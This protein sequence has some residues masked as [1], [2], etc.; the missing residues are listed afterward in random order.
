MYLFTLMDLVCVFGLVCLKVLCWCWCLRLFVGFVCWFGC[1]LLFLGCLIS[2]ELALYGVCGF[3]GDLWFY[4]FIFLG[5]GYDVGCFG[6]LRECC[7]LLVL[8]SLVRFWGWVSLLSLLFLFNFGFWICGVWLW[9][10]VLLRWCTCCFR[11][12]LACFL[13]LDVYYLEFAVDLIV[14]LRFVYLY[15]ADGC[16]NCGWLFFVCVCCLIGKC[17][18]CVTWTDLGCLIVLV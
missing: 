16:C 18:L 6:G 10:F 13:W 17:C 2:C 14:W 5:F 11:A 9:W 8:A 4:Y 3:T 12:W 7:L 1:C 15:F